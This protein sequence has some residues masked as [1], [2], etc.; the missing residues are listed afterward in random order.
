V[1]SVEDRLA[2][3]ELINLYAHIIDRQ[4]FSELDRIFTADAVF[5]LTG[6]QSGKAYHGLAEIQSMMES[7]TQHPVAHH[8]TNIVI[9][10]YLPES[11]GATQQNVFVESKGL[12]VGRNGRVGS[13]VY[14]DVVLKQND[15]QWR[16]R[17][18]AVQHLTDPGSQL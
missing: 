14:K 11:S 4:A 13:V 12:G 6:F 2:I 3:H 10:P 9:N 8:A 7:S 1:L 16:V 15:G 5:D 17:R 18:R